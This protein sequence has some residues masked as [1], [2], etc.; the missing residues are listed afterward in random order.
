MTPEQDTLQEGDFYVI[1]TSCNEKMF[2]GIDY[3]GT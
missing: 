2:V 1:L 3:N